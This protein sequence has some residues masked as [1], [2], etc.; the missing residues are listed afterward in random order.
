MALVDHKDI[1]DDMKVD[2]APYLI[3]GNETNSVLGASIRKLARHINRLHLEEKEE[4]VADA[5]KGMVVAKP[6]S[7]IDGFNGYTPEERADALAMM[8]DEKLHNK[9]LTASEIREL[10]DVFNLKQKDQDIT[11]VQSD[12]RVIDPE[13]ADIISAVNWQITEY[14]EKKEGSNG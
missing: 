12:F 13:S 5:V 3:K 9:E 2:L 10:K 6:E 7:D 14:N 1:F 8:L 4:A 11:I